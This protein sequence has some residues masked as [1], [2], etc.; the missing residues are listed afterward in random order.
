MADVPR[1]DADRFFREQ[2]LAVLGTIRS[3]GSANLS[4]VYFAWDGKLLYLSITRTRGKYH[5][6]KRD[7]RVTLC[8]L[9]DTPPYQAVTV[10][11]KAEIEEEDILDHTIAVV[12]KF[13]PGVEIDR[14]AFLEEMRRQER[15]VVKITP[16]RFVR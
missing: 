8:V 12:H 4:P 2:R 9:Q 15:V 10:Y 3:D 5:N 1:A 6:I 7:P 13:R 16:S 11:G 14:E